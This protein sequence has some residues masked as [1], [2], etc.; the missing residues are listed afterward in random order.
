MDTC[1]AKT[2]ARD[3]LRYHSQTHRRTGGTVSVRLEC[4]F[5]TGH[6]GNWCCLGKRLLVPMRG[7]GQFRNVNVRVTC[8]CVACV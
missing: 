6:Y 2:V 8:V 5:D 7:S 3:S 4:A 1:T